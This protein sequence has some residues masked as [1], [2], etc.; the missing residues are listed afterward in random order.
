MV[1]LKD[2][3]DIFEG[4]VTQYHGE[5]TT[6]NTTELSYSADDMLGVLTH[7]DQPKFN[8]KGKV[9]DFIKKMLENHNLQVEGWK[10]FQLGICEVDTY[11]VYPDSETP[12]NQELS[13]GDKATI[14]QTTKYI[15]N[16]AG[17]R[18]NIASSVLGVTHTVDVV[19]TG[20]F[21]GKFRLRHPNPAWGISGWIQDE[22]IVETYQV[23]A[24]SNVLSVSGDSAGNKIVKVTIRETATQYY[25]DS[26]TNAPTPIPSYIKSS[27][28]L[29]INKNKYRNSRYALYRNGEDVGWINENDILLGGQIIDPP[30]PD[31]PSSIQKSRIIEVEV[32]YGS[33]WDNLIN[34]VIEEIG[35]EISWRTDEG[36]YTLDIFREIGKESELPISMGYN[37]Q[38]IQEAIDATDIVTKVRAIGQPPTEDSATTASREVNNLASNLGTETTSIAYLGGG[39]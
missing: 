27:T 39:T 17:T 35:G 25:W 30:K 24:T 32:E 31:K 4:Y 7:S 19:G 15:W 28:E 10:Q 1:R 21:A 3:K 18:L 26:Y 23:G 38:E 34:H 20:T 6:D 5:I 14:K 33:T 8:F 11:T 22:D 37:L 13:I 36:V 16:D 12:V 2:S 9:S 29:T